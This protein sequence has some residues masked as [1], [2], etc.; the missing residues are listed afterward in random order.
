MHQVLLDVILPVVAIAAV[1]GLVGRRI[2]LDLATL[3]KAV[4]YLFTPALVFDGLATIELDGGDVLRLT[5]CAIGVFVINATVAL[6]WARARGVGAA[7]RATLA[8]TSAVPN[9]GN[10][11]LPM[12]RLAFGSG[13]L[14]FATVLFVIGVILNASAAVALGT[15][16]LGTHTRR[17]A[18]LAPLRFPAIYAAAA[19]IA[20]NVF[21]ID[22]PT[23]IN[24]PVTTLAQAAIPTML[25]VLGLSFRAPKLGDLEHPIA[26]SLNRLVL[27]PIAA[28]ALA[29]LLGLHGTTRDVTILMGGMPAAVNT[30]ILSAEL[31]ADA[32]LAVR[33]VV[34]S[35][36]LS[37][38]SL[39][40]LLTIL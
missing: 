13:G 20:V 9:Q 1:G 3:S 35:T 30:T 38:V 31:G 27:G 6:V 23:A 15:M 14:A 37:I 4:F 22:L 16:A 5:L 40:V 28:F 29:S 12:A 34:A 17:R 10:M 26:V 25:V 18:L 32:S 8:I 33:V 7:Q 24:E 39:T 19:G 2:G 11:G 36:L 21:D